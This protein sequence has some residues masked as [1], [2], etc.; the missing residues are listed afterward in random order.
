MSTNTTA[1]TTVPATP[2]PLTPTAPAAPATIPDAASV[3]ERIIADAA[4]IESDAAPATPNDQ[5]LALASSA[6]DIV[7]F[8]PA[9]PY[10][11]G[12]TEAEH[13]L[14]GAMQEDPQGAFDL[15][16]AILN[17]MPSLIQHNRNYVL[18][19]LGLPTDANAA[20]R[21]LQARERA[22]FQASQT[23]AIGAREI[24]NE[25]VE[26]GRRV[27]LNEL[28]ALGLA[29]A[30]YMEVE[31]G[32]WAEGESDWKRTVN[33]WTRRVLSGNKLHAQ[34]RRSAYR[35]AFEAV[36]RRVAERYRHVTPRKVAESRSGLTGAELMES[37]IRERGGAA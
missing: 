3:M 30:S 14:V 8:H 9:Q 36:Y 18:R 34:D 25:F 27:G 23:V 7:N 21:E 12:M 10:Y 28:E 32:F 1:L 24:F 16:A 15:G 17:Q 5:S 29:A 22:E 33:D 2:E 13:W 31:K 26:Q 11:Q 19:V 4:R 37:I 20:L 35:R 6:E